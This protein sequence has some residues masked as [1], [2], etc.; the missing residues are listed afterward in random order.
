[1]EEFK[2]IDIY[3]SYQEK[4]LCTLGLEYVDEF[5]LVFDGKVKFFPI[6]RKINKERNSISQN[7]LINTLRRKTLKKNSLRQKPNKIMN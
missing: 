6:F 4:Y 1:M 7:N 3:E 2:I 5:M